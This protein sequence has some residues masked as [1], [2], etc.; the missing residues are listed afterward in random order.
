M[1]NFKLIIPEIL[2][3]FFCFLA[4]LKKIE[5]LLGFHLAVLLNSVHYPCRDQ[6]V[7]YG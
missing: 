3:N 1:N 7:V 4:R 5:Y 6:L 2:Q